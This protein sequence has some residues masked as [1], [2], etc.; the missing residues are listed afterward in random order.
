MSRDIKKWE[1]SID[2]F[3]P[4]RQPL[5]LEIRLPAPKGFGLPGLL[6]LKDEAY[7]PLITSTESPSIWCDRIEEPKVSASRGQTFGP[8]LSQLHGEGISAPLLSRPSVTISVTNAPGSINS[9]QGKKV[10]KR[11]ELCIWNSFP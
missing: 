5:D 6:T 9:L 4:M 2:F 7:C 3:L 10:H 11:N 1:D 8:S